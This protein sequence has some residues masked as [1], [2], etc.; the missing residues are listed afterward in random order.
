LLL[1]KSCFNIHNA[2][3]ETPTIEPIAT[4]SATN[5]ILCSSQEN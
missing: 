4:K 2:K 1:A 5:A 3:R